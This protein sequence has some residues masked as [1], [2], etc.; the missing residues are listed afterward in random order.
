MKNRVRFTSVLL[1]IT[2]VLAFISLRAGE[3]R[4]YL[5][6]NESLDLVAATVD[7]ESLTLKDLAFYIAYEE[8]EVEKDA[9]VYNP[10]DTGEY[11]RIYSNHTFI[12]SSAKQA[13]LDMA[14]HDEIFFQM[15]KAEGIELNSEEEKYL[16][17]SCYDFWSDLEED[18]REALGISREV[19]DES[20]RKVALAEKYQYLYAEMQGAD[21]ETYSFNGEAYL[22]LLEE[23]TVEI[24]EE[25]WERVKFGSITVDH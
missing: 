22:K 10:S 4:T 8:G 3:K 24:P 14:V 20:M 25:V 2:I 17:N 12:R 1:M 21:F 19:L 7:G 15:G 6:F 18:Q 16:V 13:A 11:W 9:L 5:E 23:R